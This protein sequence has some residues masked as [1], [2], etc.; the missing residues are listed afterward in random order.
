MAK[1]YY[2]ILGIQKNAS[3]E[4]IKSAF[5]KLAHKYHPDKNQGN[6]EAEEKFKEIN[7]AYQTLS[8][9]DKRAQYDRFGSTGG[10]QSGFGGFESSGFGGFD[11]NN[12]GDIF[13]E[14]FGGQ[15]GFGG[16][17][18]QSRGS[19]ME[20]TINISLKESFFGVSRDIRIT[21]TNFCPD[22]KGSG[23]EAGSKMNTCG[24]CKGNGYVQKQA[25]SFLGV[26]NTQAVCE[27]CTGAGTVPEKKCNTCKG[28]GVK[29]SSDT[30]QIQI[31]AGI[32]HGQSLRMTGAGEAVKGGSQGDLFIHVLVDRDPVWSRVGNNLERRLQLKLSEALLGTEIELDTYSGN[33]KVAIPQG[34]NTG[35]TL[36]IKSKGFAGG[37]TPGD[38][39]LRLN[40]AMPKKLDSKQKE[41]IQKLKDSGI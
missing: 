40:V 34:T 15:A 11:F 4:E 2:T 26:I 41:Y 23:A 7:E 8:D 9:K 22:C 5:R 3:E 32:A 36:T 12:V 39:V 17:Q 6:K 1:D 37:R 27:V 21:K 29:D 10:A 16:G 28:K 38:I 19:D 31:P 13:S 25:R 35:D 20:V 14:F 24:E 33:V 30:I 18:R